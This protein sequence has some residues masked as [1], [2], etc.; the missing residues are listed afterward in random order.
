[1]R[2]PVHYDRAPETE[3]EHYLQEANTLLADADRL[4]DQPA[5]AQRGAVSEDFEQL[6]WFDLPA[7]CLVSR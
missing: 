1:V 4:T 2:Y 7:A 6:R 3:L 5:G